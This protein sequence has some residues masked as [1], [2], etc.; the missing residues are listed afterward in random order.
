MNKVEAAK[1]FKDFYTC[2]ISAENW[3]WLTEPL[4]MRFC[5]SDMI[6]GMMTVCTVLGSTLSPMFLIWWPRSI[7]LGPPPSPKGAGGGKP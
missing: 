4:A 6:W 5:A 1:G 7:A 3:S 2:F